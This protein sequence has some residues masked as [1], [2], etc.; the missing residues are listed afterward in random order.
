MTFQAAQ[1]TAQGYLVTEHKSGEAFFDVNGVLRRPNGE[2][3]ITAEGQIVSAGGVNTGHRTLQPRSGS[4]AVAMT[5][6]NATIPSAG[7][8]TTTLNAGV[9]DATFQA[10]EIV[11]HEAGERV[12]AVGAGMTMVVVGGGAASVSGK[13]EA[14]VITPGSSMA[15]VFV[16]K[17]A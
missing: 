4:W 14:L 12:F 16:A 6:A 10:M 17:V 3:A 7:A 13:G 8:G 1:L 11:L 5:D 15:E 9:F 2:V